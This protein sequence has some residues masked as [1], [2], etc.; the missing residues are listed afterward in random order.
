[1]ASVSLEWLVDALL[2]I[3]EMTPHRLP[4]RVGF[5]FSQKEAKLCVCFA[6]ECSYVMSLRALGLN[7]GSTYQTI[8]GEQSELAEGDRETSESAHVDEVLTPSGLISITS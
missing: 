4:I 8:E 3:V 1:M 2:T 7:A 6:T 5:S